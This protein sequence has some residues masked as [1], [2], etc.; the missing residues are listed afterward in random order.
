M[1]DHVGEVFMPGDFIENVRVSEKTSKAFLGPGLRQDAEA[2][3]VSKPGILR[4]KQPN[5]YWID[6]HQKRV[7]VQEKHLTEF[8]FVKQFIFYFL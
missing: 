6:S 4:H 3:V 8:N 5:I 1:S 7:R 2:I